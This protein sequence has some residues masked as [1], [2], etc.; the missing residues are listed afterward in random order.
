MVE[1]VIEEF[2]KYTSSFDKT[3]EGISLKYN[4]SFAVMD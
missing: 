2:N 1:K 3:I 4:H